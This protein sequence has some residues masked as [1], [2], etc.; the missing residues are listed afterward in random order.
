[1]LSLP[2]GILP[3]TR[4]AVDAYL[5]FVRDRSVLEG[6]AS[7]LTELFAPAIHSE[8]I[9]GMLA[10]YNFVEESMMGYF[11]KRLHSGAARRELR[12][13]TTSRR[14]RARRRAQQAA[15]DALIFKTERALG[16]AR[17]ALFCLCRA[18]TSCRRGFPAVTPARAIVN[19]KSKPYFPKYVRMQY[20]PVRKRLAVLG[21]ERVYWP[22]A[23]RGRYP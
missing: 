11:R 7:S 21:P 2:A 17:C 1:M 12:A 23:C 6:I 10:N 19:A 15:I 8:R 5:A 13:H 14:M 18:G 20:D 22:D 4:F 9:S 16:A 3:G